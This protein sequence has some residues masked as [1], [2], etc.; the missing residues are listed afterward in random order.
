MKSQSLRLFLNFPAQLMRE[1]P[2]II[3]SLSQHC[4][5]DVYLLMNLH[6]ELVFGWPG[7]DRAF[8][9]MVSV[10]LTGPHHST[11]VMSELGWQ[12]LHER[13]HQHEVRYSIG[14]NHLFS[15]GCQ[16]F[17]AH[18]NDLLYRTTQTHAHTHTR[19]HMPQKLFSCTGM[20][21]IW[22]AVSGYGEL[23]C[24]H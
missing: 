8:Y 17:Q 21:C 22:G 9:R 7:S 13:T 5:T 24:L 1:A 16:A 15:S 18:R 3:Y 10:T 14:L 4:R 6:W 20:Y 23:P 19:L 12:V 2:F 11:I